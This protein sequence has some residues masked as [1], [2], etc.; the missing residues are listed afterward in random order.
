MKVEETAISMVLNSH[1]GYAV[2]NNSFFTF[3]KVGFETQ[4]GLDF[5]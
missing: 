3:A 1:S 2:S 5:S 4:N